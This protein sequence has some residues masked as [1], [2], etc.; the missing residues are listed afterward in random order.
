MP[1][2]IP[3]YF[4]EHDDGTKPPR[5]ALC[6]GLLFYCACLEFSQ[7]SIYFFFDC[8]ESIK[9]QNPDLV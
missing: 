2:G 4:L 6:W 5:P 7:R 9:R 8:L 3:D 1:S